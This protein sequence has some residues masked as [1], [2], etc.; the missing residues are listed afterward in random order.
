MI[1]LSADFLAHVT[2]KDTRKIIAVKLFYDET[3]Y[4]PIATVATVVDG[5]QYYGALKDI[6]GSTQ[7][8]NIEQKN[9]VTINTPKLTIVNY[10]TPNGY[11]L[12]AEFNSHTYYGRKLEVYYGY[13]GQTLANML[14][15]FNGYIE[16]INFSDGNIVVTGKTF[17]IPN[18]DIMGRRIDYDNQKIGDTSVP[19]GYRIH[20]DNHNK[21]VP[22]PFGKHWCAPLQHCY[23]NETT[24]ESSYAIYDDQYSTLL[25]SSLMVTSDIYQYN[26]GKQDSLVMLLNDEEYIPLHKQDWYGLSDVV[27]TERY[28]SAIYMNGISIGGLDTN[29]HRRNDEKIF[30]TVPLRY[31][32]RT[33]LTNW[34]WAENCTYDSPALISGIFDNTDDA[35]FNLYF[36]A[37]VV[38]RFLVK[39]TLDMQKNLRADE[40]AYVR[41]NRKISLPATPSNNGGQGY[42]LGGWYIDSLNPNYS[43]PFRMGHWKNNYIP[44]SFDTGTTDYRYLGQGNLGLSDNSGYE[45]SYYGARVFNNDISYG[46][47]YDIFDEDLDD[48][49]LQGSILTSLFSDGRQGLDPFILRETLREPVGA[50]F[51]VLKNSDTYNSGDIQIYKCF[52]LTAGEVDL[53]ADD[54]IYA[55]CSGITLKTSNSLN[56]T[57]QNS[58]PHMLYRP[59]EYVEFLLSE[60]TDLSFSSDFSYSNINTKWNNFFSTYRDNSGFVLDEETT[61]DKFIEEYMQGEPFTIYTSEDGS[62]QLKMFKK[63]YSDG[64][65][66]GTLDYNDATSFDISLTESKNIYAE[67]K[68]LKTDYM[69]DIEE[70]VQDINWRVV[71]GLYDYSYWAYS[72]TANNNQFKLDSLE[73]KY[74]SYTPV[75]IVKYTDNKYY[76]C[77]RSHTHI[78]PGSTY[79]PGYDNG[80][81]KELNQVVSAP[82]WTYGGTYKGEDAESF[83]TASWF[84]NMWANRHRVIEYKTD[85]LKYLQYTIGDLVQ[86][87]NVPF[88]LVGMDIKGFNNATNFESTL[89]GQTVYGLFIITNIQKSLKSVS[90]TAMQLHDLT[91]YEIERLN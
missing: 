60:K 29:N 9:N 20:Q 33:D 26:I 63:T 25:T 24:K 49:G 10:T 6:S 23:F 40:Q 48:L 61:L 75:D 66:N 43:H 38:V 35:V 12:I 4:L 15:A 91:A 62:Y 14:K 58:N 74:S 28:N 19:S 41:S 81:W 3:H 77:V 79:L 56:S 17:V 82:D 32:P 46:W 65:E 27:Y 37:G 90:I 5:V 13:E 84:L 47:N 18:V 76:G 30:V 42:L 45:G 52:H 39:L 67:I 22:V 21:Y 83:Q 71:S 85:N 57:P 8:W 80:Y 88:S 7:K 1:T 36:N 87:E 64:D 55:A 70:Y 89:N 53:A 72:N 54:R 59:Y 69:Y 16:D 68:S 11:N 51:R 78:P 50:H 73:K 31:Y 34:Y 44:T 86:F 2:A